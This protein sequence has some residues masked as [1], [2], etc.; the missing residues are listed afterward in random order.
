MNYRDLK[1]GL[2]DENL[3]ITLEAP[4]YRGSDLKSYFERLSDLRV[5]DR[6]D[7]M[8]ICNNPI[9]KVHIDPLPISYHLAESYSISPIA[10]LTCKNS[11]LSSIQRW[12]LGADAFG[13]NNI[14]VVSGDH[15]IGD[16]EKEHTPGYMNSLTI[17]KGIK[18]HLN[19]GTL[20][21]DYSK[22]TLRRSEQD[23]G[24]HL[25]NPTKFTV[26]GVFIPGREGEISY[27]KKKIEAG[28]DFLQT[29]ITYD[30]E[31]ISKFIKRLGKEVENC[32]P[33]LIS[34][35]P[36]SSSKEIV[37]IHENI[38]EV[39][40]PD[41]VMERVGDEDD[42]DPT[43]VK[44]AVETFTYIKESLNGQSSDIDLGVHIIP[45]DNYGLA[46]KVI[47]GFDQI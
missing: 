7:Y 4:S 32:P 43:A 3:V 14:L 6:V 26:G 41:E 19:K 38:P 20:M 9:G 36:V 29:Q 39:D 34:I 15:G 42:I 16:Y 46:K 5:F 31:K 24:I 21:P 44:I 13:I 10:H 35:R 25:D 12:L 30:K 17:I 1:K 40:V 37:Y 23:D 45:G 33:I 11:T 47:D 2:E 27:T 28:V 18:D 22:A 8:N